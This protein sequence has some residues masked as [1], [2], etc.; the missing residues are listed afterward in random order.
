MLLLVAGCGGNPT[1]SVSPP[2]ASSTPSA[3]WVVYR[4]PAWGYSISMPPD[5]H[6]ITS[7]ANDTKQ[8]RSFSTESVTDVRTLAGLSP[9][10]MVVT[11]AVSQLNAGCPGDQPPVGWSESTIPA[12]A[13][14]VD[15]YTS[16]VSGHQAQDLSN[17]GVQATASSGKYCYSFVGL[18]LNHDAQVR[19]TPLFEQMLS[20]FRFGTPLAPP[21]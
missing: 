10:G 19:W 6:L 18:T 11:V 15:G 8:F 12:V 16:V 17:W 9:N 20:T 1:A 5:W 3:G 14:S 13:V 7:G 2:A 4:E 21:F